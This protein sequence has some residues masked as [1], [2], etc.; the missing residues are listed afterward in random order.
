MSKYTNKSYDFQTNYVRVTYEAVQLINNIDVDK[1]QMILECK[2]QSERMRLVISHLQNF[3]KQ[4][5][6]LSGSPNQL[7]QSLQNNIL[8][9]KNPLAQLEDKLSKSQKMTEEAKAIARKDIE[10]LK[11]LH[12]S[13]PEYDSLLSYVETLINLPWDVSSPEVIDIKKAQVFTN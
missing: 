10:R 7:T 11:S 13:S 12:K 1:K 6:N 2:T 5:S 3:S 9:S 4:N 8:D